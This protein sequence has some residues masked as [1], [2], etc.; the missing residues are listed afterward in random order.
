[1]STTARSSSSCIE[2][3]TLVSGLSIDGNSKQ[4]AKHSTRRRSRSY[5]YGMN[6][7]S[8]IPPSKSYR[9]L[10]IEGAYHWKLDHDY[11]E[12]LESVPYATNLIFPNGLS[13]I[14]LLAAQLSPSQAKRKD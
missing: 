10:L 14:S 6:D 13:K 12:Q 3:Y 4:R 5:N 1:M 9:D 7:Y 11:V 8:D 2:A